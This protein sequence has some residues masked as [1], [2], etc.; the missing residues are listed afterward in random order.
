M[1]YLAEVENFRS[2]RNEF[3][4]K[5]EESP[6][7]TQVREKLTEI[8]FF[9]IKEEFRIGVNLQSRSKPKE[10][11]VVNMKGVTKTVNKIGKIDFTCPGSDE[12]QTGDHNI[13]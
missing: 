10:T 7:P 3:L 6:I 2:Q 9:P 4:L 11:D 12:K 13:L 8:P 5:S 1:S